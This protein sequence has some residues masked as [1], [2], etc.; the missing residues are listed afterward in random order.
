ML[1]QELNVQNAL[2]NFY[3]ERFYSIRQCAPYNHVIS[4]PELLPLPP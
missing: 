3:Q 2:N 1:N 4:A